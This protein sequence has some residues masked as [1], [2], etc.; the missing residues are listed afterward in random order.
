[1]NMRAKRYSGYLPVA[2]RLQGG[3]HR[4]ETGSIFD[5]HS[6]LGRPGAVRPGVY[7]GIEMPIIELAE[8]VAV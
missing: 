7:P 2:A 5:V 3:L 4:Y 1:L 6:R 8:T